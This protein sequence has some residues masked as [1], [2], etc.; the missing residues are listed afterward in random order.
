MGPQ[1]LFQFS[2]EDTRMHHYVDLW[3]NLFRRFHKKYKKP[4]SKF[5]IKKP[6]N[7]TPW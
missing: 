4:I 1:I 6:K 7:S 2:E 5:Y 3:E